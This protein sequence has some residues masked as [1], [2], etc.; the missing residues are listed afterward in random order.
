[1]EFPSFV[2]GIAGRS[3]AVNQ[4]NG[5]S[6]FFRLEGAAA[7]WVRTEGRPPPGK[8]LGGGDLSSS[9]VY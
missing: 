2:P 4:K 9:G 8:V 3:L 7:P 1:M 6:L 5:D